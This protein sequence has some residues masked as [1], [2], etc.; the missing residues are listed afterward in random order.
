MEHLPT[1]RRKYKVAILEAQSRLFFR[2]SKDQL[3]RRILV[4]DDQQQVRVSIEIAL[5]SNN[6]EVVSVGSGREAL[7]EFEKSSFDLAIVDIY[8]PDM[9]GVA[10]IKALRQRNPILPIVAISGIPLSASGRTT[11]DLLPNVPNLSNVVRLK[12]PFRPNELIQAV[13]SAIDVA[14]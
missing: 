4:I 9:D 13:Q 11:L 6:F 1:W 10:L 14:A 5:Q 8:M 12:K 7:R 2:T 3:M